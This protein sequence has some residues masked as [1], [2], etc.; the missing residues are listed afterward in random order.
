MADFDQLKAS[1]VDATGMPSLSI[2]SEIL[3]GLIVGIIV[4]DRK[5]R[6]VFF[7]NPWASNILGDRVDLNDY[8]SASNLFL[9][10]DGDVTEAEQPPGKQRE[11][12]LGNSILGYTVYHPL[13]T[14]TSILFQDITEKARLESIAEAVEMTNNLGYIFSQI[15]HELGNPT[16]SIK[17]TMEVLRKNLNNYSRETILNYVDRALADVGRVEYL[18]KSLRNFSL[19]EDLDIRDC[20][21]HSFMRNLLSLVEGTFKSK[22]IRMVTRIDP[23]PLYGLIDPSALQQVMLNLVS[24]AVDALIDRS[25]PSIT[26]GMKKSG[27]LVNISF[28]DNGCGIPYE[29]RDR[30]FTAFFTSK[31]KGTGLGLSISAKMLARMNSTI[32]IA[33]EENVG[34][35]VTVSIPEGSPEGAESLPDISAKRDR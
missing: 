5:N 29:Q 21:M 26:I 31:P 7:H 3:K 18:L 19:Y 23:S 17:M 32:E 22:G 34:T 8:E 35:T 13:E 10:H 6:T 24:N 27:R 1:P 28:E 9:R 16:N 4:L 2:Y 15:R 14:H 20:C 33:S 12:R 11:I 25:S 30:V